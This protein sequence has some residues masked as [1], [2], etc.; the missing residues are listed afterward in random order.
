[1]LQSNIFIIL[2][3][4]ITACI[5]QVSG[6]LNCIKYKSLYTIMY[7]IHI[8]TWIYVI[9]FAVLW[10]FTSKYNISLFSLFITQIFTKE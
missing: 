3:M 6:V 1:M 2:I 8:K 10:I 9:S 4:N 7:M 5:N